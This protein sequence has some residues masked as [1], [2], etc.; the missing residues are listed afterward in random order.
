VLEAL[1]LLLAQLVRDEAVTAF[2]MTVTTVITDQGFAPALQGTQ[3]D[4][5]LVAGA[6]Q[7]CNSGRR[8]AD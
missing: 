7:A 8:L 5:D 2:A 6:Q 3:A 1:A 4:V